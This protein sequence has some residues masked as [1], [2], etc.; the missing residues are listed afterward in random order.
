MITGIHAI[1]FSREAVTARAFLVVG[2]SLDR[3]L[4]GNE[5]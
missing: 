4:G 5:Y 1:V 2:P 3:I